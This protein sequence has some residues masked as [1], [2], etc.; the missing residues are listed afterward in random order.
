MNSNHY[1]LFINTICP[2]QRHKNF[3][4]YLLLEK[5]LE[6]NVVHFL[7]EYT[8][9]EQFI[10]FHP[11]IRLY[12]K[13]AGTF[14]KL[15]RCTMKKFLLFATLLV[16]PLAA[17]FAQTPTWSSNVAPI[18]YNHCTSCHHS[19]GIAPFSLITYDQ[20]VL[21]SVSMKNDVQSKKMPPWP[22]S[23]SYSHF[24]HER[25]LSVA[26]INT[27]V[28]WANGGTPKGDTTLAPPV[29]VYSTTGNIPGTPDLVLRI[30][31]YTSTASTG[32]VY[33]CFAIPSGLLTDKY[34]TAFEAIPGNASCVHHVLVYAD[35]TGVCAGLD[36]ASAGPGYPDFGG[37]GSSSATLVG[38]WVP[39]SAPMIYPSGFG[40]K[41]AARSDIVLQI[42]Y[43]AGTTGMKD[44][45]EIHFF[46]APTTTTVRDLYIQPILNYWTNIS[47]SLFIPRNTTKAFK[48]SQAIPLDLSLLAVAPHMHLIG[49]TIKSYAVHPA[50]DTDKLINIPSWD[51]HW[52][53]FYSFPRIKHLPAGSTLK[54]EANYD[55]TT[56]N[57]ENPHTPPLDVSG[58]ENTSDEMML[59]YFIFAQYQAGD[60]N[61]I[62]DSAVAL[63]TPNQF[64]NYYHGQQLLDVCPNPAIND[65][66][67]KCYMD[68]ADKGTIDLVDMQ[69]KIVKRLMDNENVNQ[70][71]SAFTFNLSGVAAGTY[72]LRMQT[73]QRLLTQKIVIAH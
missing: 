57:P 54:A 69:G 19:G 45:T 52:Q 47:P 34:I 72:S 73:H 50:G 5:S 10:K 25:V 9:Y 40:V 55:N 17:S 18:L 11:E 14:I 56:A 46:F 27:I 26:D 16:G 51:F 61:I 37:V 20:A 48:E 38:A 13:K 39:G 35:T 23:A 42:H 3:R 36:S 63:S 24:A 2:G 30:P 67:I 6:K 44:S 22:P 15:Y 33:Q 53:G 68:D 62:M 7:M 12:S 4:V 66:V 29:P 58:G 49:R 64:S 32:D 65:I 70:G 8:T 71:Y 41:L 21:N 1:R 28:N 60:E 31:T 43:P 59:V